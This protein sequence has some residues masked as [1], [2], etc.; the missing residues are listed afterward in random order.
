MMLRIMD[1]IELLLSRCSNGK[2][3][4]PAPD[5][6]TMRIALAAAVRAPDHAGLHPFRFRLVRGAAREQLGEL[7]ASTLMRRNPS[8][9]PE[10]IKKARSNP[11]RAPLLIVV[12]ARLQT[13]PKVPMIEQVLCAGNAAY[14]ILLALHARGFAGIWRTGDA[15]YDDDMKLA[16]GFAPSDAIVGFIYAG[17]PTQPAPALKRANPDDI[18]REW[19]GPELTRDHLS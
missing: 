4:E 3:S 13:H 2:L 5:A 1:A 19:L 11:L 12:G 16:L 6:E 15:A 17:T 14:A 18:A 10:A 8:A 9:P 7:L